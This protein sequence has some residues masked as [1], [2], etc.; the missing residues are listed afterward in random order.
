MKLQI[1]AQK[2]NIKSLF[3]GIREFLEEM[4]D[5]LEKKHEAVLKR[6]DNSLKKVNSDAEAR[7][8]MEDHLDDLHR[9]SDNYSSILMSSTFI[10]A[11][12]MFESELGRLCDAIERRS[13][14]SVS[15]KDL[16]GRGILKSKKYL[17]KVVEIN[18]SN[19]DSEWHKIIDYNKI[20]NLI[21]H[22]N[23][24]LIKEKTKPLDK[25]ESLNIVRN[26][27]YLQYNERGAFYISRI[28]YINDFCD[29]SEKFLLEILNLTYQKKK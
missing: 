14:Y 24:N 27:I 3:S 25:Q 1:H 19:L 2:S 15:Q 6:V 4:N 17:E 29:A 22:N 11:Y 9:Y 10:S 13:N 23:S 20:R 5:I 28:E 16:N 8:T 26:S 7:L 12:S 21:V 18:L